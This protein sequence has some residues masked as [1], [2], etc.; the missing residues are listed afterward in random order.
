MSVI[1]GG[2]SR[3]QFLLTSVSGLSSA[4]LVLRWPAI[5]AADAHART[6]A[7]EKASFQFF[8]DEQAAEVEALAA[9]IIPVD[10]TP[11]ARDA[12][13]I[14]F[15]DRALATFD[16]GKQL[17]YK[18]GL[19]MLRA[20][21]QQLFFGKGKFSDLSSEQQLR[22]LTAIEHT[23]FFEQ[24]RVHTIMGFLARPEYGGNRGEAGWKL[25]GFEDKM[26]NEPPFGY[27]D[28]EFNKAGE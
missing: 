16:S 13:V 26:M 25:I 15:I 5:V 22:L 11:G 23:D 24:V 10:E 8:S 7:S 2:A 27:Y 12:R 18:Q 17:V 28:R 1:I 6:S 21:T 20:K 19:P 14:Y 4:W 3:R 9:Q